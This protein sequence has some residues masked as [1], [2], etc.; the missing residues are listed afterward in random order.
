MDSYQQSVIFG[1]QHVEP[2][3]VDDSFTEDAIKLITEGRG[4]RRG[5]LGTLH[6][7]VQAKSLVAWF[8]DGD[9][10]THKYWAYIA[11]KL[12]VMIYHL[13]PDEWFPAYEHLYALLSDHEEII[14]WY[15]QNKASYLIKGKSKDRDNPNQPAFHGYQALLALNAEWDELRKR[16]E[17]VLSMEIK[18]DRKYLIDHRFYLGLANGDLV[19]MEAA[20]TEL[21]SSKI[22]RVRNHEMAFGLT[23]NLIATHATIYAKIAWRYGYKLDINTPW[24][25]KAWLPVQ[26][27]ETYDEP[28][29]FMR[30]FDI[31]TPFDGE[32]SVFSPVR[33]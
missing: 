22:A 9:L 19:G 2:H 4:S 29:D 28:W 11:A 33:E 27:L 6:S 3:A 23:E 25:P 13:K 10:Q 14:R 1:L 8:R 12:R 21:T 24:I 30:E 15:S 7:S 26:P 18:K 16:C 32:L 5:C 31:F 17:Q 20:L